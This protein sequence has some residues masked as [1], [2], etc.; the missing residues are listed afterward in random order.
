MPVGA[1]CQEYI[2]VSRIAIDQGRLL[3]LQAARVLDAHGNKAARQ[4]VA[5]AKVAVA[6]MAQEVVD[7][8]IQIHGAA[9]VSQDLPLAIMFAGARS[10]RIAD[11][12]DEVHL[13]SIAAAELQRCARAMGASEAMVRAGGRS[14]KL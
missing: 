5:E 10:L 13:I 9:G 14:S 12:P 3:V 8:A 4:L 7:R 2:A 6:R 11:G 1:R